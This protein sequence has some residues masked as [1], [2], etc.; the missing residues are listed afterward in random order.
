MSAVTKRSDTEKGGVL[1]E[2]ALCVGLFV[3]FVATV[4]DLTRYSQQNSL[5][6]RIL[7]EV[8]EEGISYINLTPGTFRGLSPGQS[9]TPTASNTIHAKL[10]GDALRRLI[11]ELPGIKPNTLCVETQL[12]H[13]VGPGGEDRVTLLATAP[14]EVLLFAKNALQVSSK[15]QEYVKR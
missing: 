4:W 5:M 13:G 7:R 6:Q 15:V 2:L 8:T 10:Q 9:C 11:S 1:I 12:T 14:Y 3:F